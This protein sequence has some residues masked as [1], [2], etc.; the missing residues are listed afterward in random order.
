MGLFFFRNFLYFTKGIGKII[1]Y[2][3]YENSKTDEKNVQ[4]NIDLLSFPINL[5]IAKKNIKR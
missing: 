5:R 4:N 1:K 2:I 3:K